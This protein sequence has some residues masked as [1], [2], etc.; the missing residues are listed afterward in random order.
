MGVSTLRLYSGFQ[1][2]EG[3]AFEAREYSGFRQSPPPHGF[4]C[5]MPPWVCVVAVVQVFVCSDSGYFG[6]DNGEVIVCCVVRV[7]FAGRGQTS[8][9]I[10]VHDWLLESHSV[11]SWQAR[12][13]VN[14][15]VGKVKLGKAQNWVN[16]EI[17]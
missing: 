17:G 12:N 4:L 3:S 7:S 16:H 10:V 1:L 8:E 2:R 11:E 13:W 6:C 14:Q 15:K 5:E 9:D